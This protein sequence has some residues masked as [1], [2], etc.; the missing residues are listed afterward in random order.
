MLYRLVSAASLL[1]LASAA[2]FD[3]QVGADGGLDF[4][5]NVITAAV[6]DTVTYHF[7]GE[8]HNVVEFDDTTPCQPLTGGFS[9]PP[10]GGTSTFVV[11]ITSTDA[12]YFYCSVANHCASGMVGIINPASDDTI[13]GLQA[14]TQG[15]TSGQPPAGVNGGVLVANGVT[16]GAASATSAG[17]STASSGAK[18]TGS[19]PA[20]STASTTAA[21][22]KSSAFAY[23]TAVPAAFAIVA[24]AVAAL[25]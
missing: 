8:T 4:N 23:A 24:G 6:G 7:G 9:I 22:A 21:S 25:V 17:T 2:N 11:N 15:K 16:S 13:T 5:P 1:A 12:K 3:V 20:G 18:T 14:K 10:Q 19:S